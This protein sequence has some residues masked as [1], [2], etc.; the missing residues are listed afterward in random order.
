[1]EDLIHYWALGA[2]TTAEEPD[3]YLEQV[4][5]NFKFVGTC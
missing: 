2:F 1:M 5:I 3:Y 4:V